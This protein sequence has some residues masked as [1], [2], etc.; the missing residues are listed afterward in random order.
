MTMTWTIDPANLGEVLACAGIARLVWL[1]DPL[2]RTGF[3]QATFQAPTAALDG[4]QATL[5]ETDDGLLLCGHTIDW[6]QPWGLN[7]ALKNWAGQ[8]SALTVHRHSVE[9]A[10]QQPPRDWRAFSAPARG[11]LYVDTLGM[12]Q[13]EVLGWSL[14]EHTQYRVAGRPWLELLASLG[15]QAFP[16]AGT[17]ADGFT[18]HLWRPAPLPVAIAAFAGHGS[19]VYSRQGYRARTE[20]SGKLTFLLPAKPL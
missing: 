12:W 4:L 2:G 6:W 20:K 17:R 9:Q 1:R 7:Q 5:A 3:E 11:Q 14:N 8:Q 19:G 13:A 15:L 16:V 18:Y 10:Q